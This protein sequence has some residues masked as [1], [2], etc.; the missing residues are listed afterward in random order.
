M[1][2]GALPVYERVTHMYV[3]KTLHNLCFYVSMYVQE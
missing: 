1:D 2:T 3:N